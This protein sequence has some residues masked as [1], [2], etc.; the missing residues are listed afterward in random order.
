MRNRIV[1]HNNGTCTYYIGDNEVTE[2]EYRKKYPKRKGPI[3]KP[4]QA[5]TSECWP[6]KSDGLAVHPSRIKQQMEY[7]RKHGIAS[8]YDPV[9]GRAILKDRGQR[10]DMMKLAG[11]HDK[12]GG[13][14]DD[15]HTGDTRPPDITPMLR[16]LDRDLA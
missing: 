12:H 2:K 9:D 13:Y 14:G 5:H 15:H 4:L 16:E 3:G 10:R 1:F 7:D 8:E 6:M 11:V